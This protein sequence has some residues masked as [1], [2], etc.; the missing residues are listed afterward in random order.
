MHFIPITLA[1]A[2][3]FIGLVLGAP[4]NVTVD[5]YGADPTSKYGISYQP[6]DRWNIGQTCTGCEAQPDPSQAYGG[7]WHDA[8]FDPSYSNRNTPQT[9]VFD[10]TGQ[11]LL[12]LSESFY[13]DRFFIGTALYV[14]GIQ[15][16]STTEPVSGADLTFWI[17]GV[18]KNTYAYTPTQTDDSYT[19][20]KLLFAIEG[21]EDAS[22][23]FTFQNGQTGG[24]ISLVLFDYLIYTK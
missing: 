20:N 9:A 6:G 12:S 7:T 10:F 15:S 16:H 18:Q 3:M 23:A 2:R 21:L 24:P 11:S 19:Y 1:L 14:F 17:D 5:D 4:T 22:H 13:V 8:T